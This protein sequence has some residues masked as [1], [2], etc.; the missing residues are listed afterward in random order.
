MTTT[1]AGKAAG[2]RGQS[3]ARAARS[4][5]PTGLV[6]RLPVTLQ[7][8]AVVQRT[9]ELLENAEHKA[10]EL[11][12]AGQKSVEAQLERVKE[13]VAQISER[14]QSER[15]SLR[16]TVEARVE[17]VQEGLRLIPG[18]LEEGLDAALG[19][20]GLMRVSVHENRLTA[21]RASLKKAAAKKK[22]AA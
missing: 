20:V 6:E 17:Q 4:A 13:G 5:E 21:L 19:T 10:A 2:K 3:R 15:D 11:A 9:G 22:K 12:E 1:T 18:K 7:E 8:S 14:V 16:A